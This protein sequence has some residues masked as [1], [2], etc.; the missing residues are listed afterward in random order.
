[1]TTRARWLCYLA[2]GSIALACAAATDPAAAPAPARVVVRAAVEPELADPTLAGEPPL[3]PPADARPF[4]GE[5]RESWPDREGCSDR[6][7]VELGETG[8][9]VAG[10]D[11]NDGR[12]YVFSNVELRRATLGF[13]LL[14]PDTG[15]ALHY[16]LELQ[17]DGSLAGSVTGPTAGRVRWLRP[18]PDP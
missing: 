18:E 11:C 2:T 7:S 16:E 6:A 15:V 10:A 17:R 4:L 8:L 13:D 9:L 12:P 14:V 1:M 3:A 5:W